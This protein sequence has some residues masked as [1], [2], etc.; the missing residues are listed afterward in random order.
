[1]SSIPLRIT[2]V[3][4]VL[5]I[6]AGENFI[7]NPQGFNDNLSTSIMQYSGKL[8]EWQYIYT[9]MTKQNKHKGK[10]GA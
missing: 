7:L 5:Y 4:F 2:L 3:I 9:I 6:S 10:Y 8:K 1:M